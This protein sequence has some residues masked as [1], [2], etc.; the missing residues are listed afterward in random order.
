MVR[1]WS[2]YRS[3]DRLEPTDEPAHRWWRPWRA[4]AAERAHAAPTLREPAVSGMEIRDAVTGRSCS[5]SLL[6]VVAASPLVQ[7]QSALTVTAVA[8]A[9][10]SALPY[11]LFL[12]PDA[13]HDSVHVLD[14]SS[15]ED[16]E[17]P[18]HV[19]FVGAPG[20]LVGPRAV[21]GWGPLVAVSA[22]PGNTTGS[23]TVHVFQELVRCF[24]CRSFG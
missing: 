24:L 17:E 10:H 13:L 18:R 19:G 12:L 22:W 21:T 5:Q 9:G 16:S 3:P 14:L 8:V 7:L 2:K 20:S 15:R 4:L 1:A 6:A 11:P 23:H